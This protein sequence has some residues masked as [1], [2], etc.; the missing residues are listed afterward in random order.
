MMPGEQTVQSLQ[1]SYDQP[2]SG[3]FTTVRHNRDHHDLIHFQGSSKRRNPSDQRRVFSILSLLLS[4][5]GD[6]AT[7][8]RPFC[9]HRTAGRSDIYHVTDIARDASAFR[10]KTSG[11]RRAGLDGQFL[12]RGCLRFAWHGVSCVRR[13][14]VA[15]CLY[16]CL[17]F[18]SL[19][20]SP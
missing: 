6:I 1:A 9:R 4:L 3:V 10:L 14:L 18:C 17:V 12:L 20:D 11:L 5:H 13:S 2:S 8:A 16:R 15:V 7:S 19:E